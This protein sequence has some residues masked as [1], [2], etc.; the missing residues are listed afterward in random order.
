MCLSV[1][2]VSL[3]VFVCVSERDCVCLRACLSVSLSVPVC[4]SERVCLCL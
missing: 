3:S 1:L 2:S 4:V